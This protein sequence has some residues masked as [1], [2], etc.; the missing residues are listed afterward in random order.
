MPFE[1]KPKTNT[2]N[3]LAT[4]VPIGRLPRVF[5]VGAKARHGEYGW[6]LVEKVKGNERWVRWYDF[7]EVP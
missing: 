2:N 7:R 4:A 6:V 3:T 5:P 1:T